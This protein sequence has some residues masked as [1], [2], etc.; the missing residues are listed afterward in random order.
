[1]KEV[2]ALLNF[3]T[4]F[5][6]LAV[7]IVI[8]AESGL[9][10]GFF[11]PGDSLL[12]ISGTLVQRQIFHVDIVLF[13]ACLWLAAV[14]GNSTGYYLG[15]KFGRKLFRRPDSRFFR[16][17]YL[18]QAEKFYEKNGSKTIVI[19]MFVPIARAFA[20]VV[21]GIAHMSYKKFA[22]FN[23]SGAF[24]WVSSFTLIGYLA[25][26]VIEKYHIN[27]ELAALIVIF[28][29]LLPGIIHLLQEPDNRQ[30]I[31]HHA[32]RVVTRNKKT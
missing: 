8:F 22:L 5:G 29:S 9:M 6:W 26:G 20:P 32:K 30:K 17:E 12:F 25:G 16:Q 31:K 23:I 4:N 2:E 3:I 13:I 19:A 10:A 1:M 15:R 14:L 11:L 28:L 24:V 27:I 18:E 21:A 7:I